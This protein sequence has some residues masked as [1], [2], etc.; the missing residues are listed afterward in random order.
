MSSVLSEIKKRNRIILRSAFF[1]YF[2]FFFKFLRPLITLNLYDYKVFYNDGFVQYIWLAVIPLFLMINWNEKGIST[3]D[4]KKDT[5]EFTWWMGLF[6][7]A[8]L[9][10][11]V[12][13]LESYSRHTME[14]SEIALNFIRDIIIFFAC[15]GR[16]FIKQ[17][18]RQL[19]S[20]VAI[21]LPLFISNLI[22]EAYWTY[23]STIILAA[24]NVIFWIIPLPHQVI[25]SSYLVKLGDFSVI[26]GVPCA[27]FQSLTAFLALFILALVMMKKNH[28]KLNTKKIILWMVGGLVLVY[29]LNVL[30]ILLILLVG[31][32][33]SQEF[34]I[35]IFH[36]SI[37]AILFL[38]FFVFYMRFA[39]S[40]SQ[41]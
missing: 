37:G 17:F 27:G 6:I 31:A 34:A 25:F 4:Y 41:I 18:R 35:T 40:R 16:H 7:L 13:F 15:F 10:I 19:L 29:L 21:I 30:R 5:K 11:S 36:S 38:L 9:F 1:L 20:I 24:L 28:A 2:V 26:I 12:R 33:F 22:E 39:I 14:Y 3:A 8:S 32:L 23:S